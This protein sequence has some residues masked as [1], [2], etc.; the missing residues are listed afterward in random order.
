MYLKLTEGGLVRVPHFYYSAMDIE[1]IRENIEE[2]IYPLEGVYL[3]KLDFKS[4]TEAKGRLLIVLDGD[5]G[6][7]IDQCGV[8][9][10]KLSS[11]LEMDESVSTPYTL[12]VTSFGVGEPL[13]LRRQYKKNVERDIRVLTIAGQEVEGKLIEVDENNI[14]LLKRK[15]H[16]H[17]KS[18]DKEPT[19]IEF[20]DISKTKVLVSF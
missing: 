1:E 15:V 3:V 2:I 7:T 4:G 14:V 5:N 12:E 9:S 10:K 11:I 16:K 6:V 20:A 18:Y 8:V 19:K 13:E 17:K